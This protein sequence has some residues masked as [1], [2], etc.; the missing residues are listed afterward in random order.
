MS[1]VKL[2]DVCNITTGKLDSNAAEKNGQYP[3]FTCAP[4]YLWI[5]SFAFDE[6]AIL[7]AGNNA[8]GNFHCQRYS[9]KFNAY[10]RTYVITAKEGFDI[11]YI[12][13]TLKINLDLLKKKAQGSQTKFLTM[14]LLDEFEIEKLPLIE[15]KN[16]ANTLK[17]IDLKIEK[18]KKINDELEEMARTIYDYWFLQFDFPNKNGKPY[19]SSGGKMIW[20][21]MLKREIPEG[22][23]VSKVN[24]ILANVPKTKKYK[25]NEYKLGSKYPIIDQSTEYI[26]GYTD[27][28]NDLLDYED[29]IVFG[30]HTKCVKYINFSFA[31]G[32]DGTQII[33]SENENISNYL[34]YR[35][36]LDMD[37]LSQGYSRYFKFLKDKF[38]I[39]PRKKVTEE[40]MKH[41]QKLLDKMRQVII[42]N[43]E[44]ES[45][46]D[47]LLPLLMNGQ[48]GFKE[49]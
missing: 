5:N 49:C 25:T 1:K 22:W 42:E 31:R 7:L 6:D 26:C 32:A 34:L 12:F 39:I 28:E 19:K 9:G 2:T 46:R 15:Q 33:I 41:M 11:D 4:E 27:N 45:L 8:S 35:Q 37:L 40:Y 21:E 48:V 29:C 16:I 47:F 23:S 24:D 17:C 36:I 3:Y 38:V 14:Q 10:Q 20:N 30:D 43:R 13:Y 44:L 18:N